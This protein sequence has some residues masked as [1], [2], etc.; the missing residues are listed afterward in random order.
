MEA[1]FELLV[2]YCNLNILEYKYTRFS[3]N[4]IFLVFN[5]YNCLHRCE[6]F[7]LSFYYSIHLHLLLSDVHIYFCKRYRYLKE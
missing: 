5:V 3:N 1:L 2:L 7:T 6:L 4:D